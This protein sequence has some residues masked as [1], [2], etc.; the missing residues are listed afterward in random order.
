MSC[1]SRSEVLYWLLSFLPFGLP[2]SLFTLLQICGP[3]SWSC[4]MPSLF[5]YQD[6][7][8]HSFCL[9]HSICSLEAF[10]LI[11]AHSSS[12]SSFSPLLSPSLSFLLPWACWFIAFNQF[13]SLDLVCFSLSLYALCSLINLNLTFLKMT[14]P[15]SCLPWHHPSI[16]TRLTIW[17]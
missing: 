16:C 6:L 3:P 4:S 2:F 10:M 11:F 12:P 1:F 15:S 9:E 8:T 13:F 7:F 5:F 14:S 17:Q